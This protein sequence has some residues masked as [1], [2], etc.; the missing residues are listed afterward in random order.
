MATGKGKPLKAKTQGR[1]RYETGPERLW[2][3]Q[4]IRRLRKPEGV[5]QPGEVYPVLVAGRFC[6]T[7]KGE[8]TS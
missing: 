1:F 4:D 7:S 3:E 5:A 8:E 6:H 2:S